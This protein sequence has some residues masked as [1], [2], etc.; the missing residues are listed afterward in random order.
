MMAPM[1]GRKHANYQV[2]SVGFLSS[3]LC[4]VQMMQDQWFVQWFVCIM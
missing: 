1:F 4:A 2:E 3:G